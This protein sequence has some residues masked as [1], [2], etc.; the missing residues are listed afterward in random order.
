MNS[1]SWTKLHAVA[2]ATDLHTYVTMTLTKTDSLIL[3]IYVLFNALKS[4]IIGPYTGIRS[5]LNERMEC[6][7]R[8]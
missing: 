6:L 4:W 3:A 5:K 7:D 1:I 2:I 8:F